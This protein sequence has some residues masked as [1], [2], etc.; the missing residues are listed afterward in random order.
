MSLSNKSLG[1]FTGHSAHKLFV[2]G[3]GVTREKY[4]MEKAEEVVRGHRKRNFSSFHT[5]H[6]NLNEFEAIETFRE[7]TGKII[8][9]LDQEFFPID[10]NSGATPDAAEYDFSNVITASVDVKCP[11]ETFYEQKLLFIKESKPEFQN[12]PKEMFFQ[13][14]MQMMALT[15]HNESLGHP[16]VIK[17]YLV[18]YMTSSVIDD[19]GN[20][21]EYNLPIESRMFYAVILADEK[22]QSDLRL[23]IAQ[24]AAERD[25]LIELFKRPILPPVDEHK[26][27]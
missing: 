20:K 1:M 4:I 18:R 23:Q 19:D 7:I 22:V 21:I 6:G 15:K 14:Q 10:E 17:H 26:P 27:F 24:A 13:A 11:T 16:P 25:I 9:Y 8:S 2:G 5:E 3:K 12:V